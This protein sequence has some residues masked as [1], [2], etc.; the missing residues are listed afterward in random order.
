[1][2]VYP[3]INE[4][5]GQTLPVL[6]DAIKKSIEEE[7]AA[8][9]DEMN[10]KFDEQNKKIDE[11]NKKIDEQNKTIS[12]LKNMMKCGVCKQVNDS[13]KKVFCKTCLRNE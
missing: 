7:L 3:R 4:A 1:M 6:D 11:Q 13:R 10:R 12:D 8:I 9:R 5:I 2:S